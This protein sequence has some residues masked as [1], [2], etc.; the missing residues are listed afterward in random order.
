MHAAVYERL[1]AGWLCCYRI[2]WV[3]IMADNIIGNIFATP[4][5]QFSGFSSLSGMLEIAGTP[6]VPVSRKL[7]LWGES[8][9]KADGAL[10][11]TRLE[12]LAQTQSDSAGDWRFENLNPEKKYTVIGYDDSDTYAP[13][14]GGG[15]SCDT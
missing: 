14:I 9:A 5:L 8:G 11:P 4:S 10:R 2:G 7:T 1:Y 13:T 12:Y 6:D 15:L 3:A